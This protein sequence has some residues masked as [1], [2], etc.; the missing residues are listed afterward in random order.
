[1]R[2]VQ[3]MYSFVDTLHQAKLKI[4]GLEWILHR[5]HH[6][7]D[8]TWPIWLVDLLG[9]C[10]VPWWASCSLERSHLEPQ[11]QSLRQG[12][13]PRVVPLP[14]ASC[15]LNHYKWWDFLLAQLLGTL[16]DQLAKNSSSSI[17]KFPLIDGWTPNALLLLLFFLLFLP[18]LGEES[19]QTQYLSRSKTLDFQLHILCEEKLNDFLRLLLETSNPIATVVCAWVM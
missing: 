6:L 14:K 18:R 5:N 2:N 19:N 13:V 7:G 12:W 9:Q 16:L 4:P 10:L 15:S 8:V 17:R 3:Y 1:M 11:N